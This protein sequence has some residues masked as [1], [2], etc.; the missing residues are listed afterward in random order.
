MFVT[1]VDVVVVV[2][3]VVVEIVLPHQTARELFIFALLCSLPSLLLVSQIR[4]H[5]AGSPPPPHPSSHL[6]LLCRENTQLV[7]LLSTRVGVR[8]TTPHYPQQ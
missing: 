5:R 1:L 6:A 3:V 4:G 7:L 8:L 2:V